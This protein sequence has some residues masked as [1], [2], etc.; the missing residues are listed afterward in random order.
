MTAKS[1]VARPRALLDVDE[2]VAYLLRE[3][4]E[5]VTLA[6]ID[7]LQSAYD[8]IAAFPESGSN[9]HAHELTLPGLRSRPIAGYPYLVFYLER[10]D[11]IDVWRVLHAQRDI[12]AHM[13]EAD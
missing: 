2:A 7:A 10:R 3:A 13:A 9:R 11:H 6:F 4:G 8:L 5:N 12:P 1:V